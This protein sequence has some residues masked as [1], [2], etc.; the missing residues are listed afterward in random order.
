[1]PKYISGRVKTTPVTGL[2]SDR[3][4][5]LSLAD[6]EPSLGDPTV[7]PSSIGAKPVESG[8]QYIIVAVEGRPGE[9]YWIQNQA[10]VT[11]GSISVFEEGVLVGG[12][13]STTQL[14]FRGTAITAEG[15]GGA[16][17]GYA[18][19]ITLVPP[20]NEKE[21][22]FKESNDFATDTTFTFDSTQNLLAAGDR[23]T[24][25]TGGTVITTTASGFVGIGTT[26]PISNLIA[27]P[28]IGIETL[29]PTLHVEGNIRLT[30]TFIDRLG[31]PGQSG[32]LLIKEDDAF[33]GLRW[34]DPK[35]VTFG[36][37]GL[38]GQIQYRGSTSILEGADLFYYDE[39]NNFVG[40]GSTQPTV[41]LDVIGT[42]NFD[43]DVTVERNFYV[44]GIST[45]FGNSVFTG[46]IDAN[47]NLDV[48][49]QTDLDVL[50]VSQLATFSGNIDANGNLDV[51]GQT[52]LDI[53]NV[54]ELATFS[55]NLDI[56]ASVDIQN[57]LDV[58]GTLDVTGAT[59]LASA[60]GITTTGGD[61][62][63]G[64]DL[65]VAGTFNITDL[66]AETGN[67]TVSLDT[68]NFRATGISTLGN[69]KVS[70]NTVDTTGGN[71]ILQANAQNNAQSID[72]RNR[73]VLNNSTES[74]AVDNGSFETIGGVGIA[75]NLNV[76]G[77]VSFAGDGSGVD[78][79]LAS[80]GGITTTGG[81]LYVGGDF[82]VNRDVNFKDLTVETLTVSVAATIANLTL[83]NPGISVTAIL[84][85]DTMISNRDDALATQ[86]SIKAYVDTQVGNQDLD[87]V[88][89]F[90]A[91][92]AVDLDTQVFDIG[93]VTGDIKTTSSGQ[94]LTIESDITGVI[95]GTY[96]SA[97]R[98]GI[99]TVNDKGKITAASDVDIDLS[100]VTVAAADKLTTP[101][102]I[103]FSEDVVAIGKTFDGTQDVGFALTLTSVFD[104]GT[105]GGENDKVLSLTVDDKGRITG[106]T[107]VAIDF[108]SVGSAEKV[109]I[110]TTDGSEEPYFLTFVADTS[111]A[112]SVYV[113]AGLSYYPTT[114]LVDFD[115]NVRVN[116]NKS[117]C[118]GDDTDYATWSYRSG[119]FAC[120]TPGSLNR[121]TDDGLLITN[122]GKASIFE[123]Q[124]AG[125]T[126]FKGLG[127]GDGAFWFVD[128]NWST[129]L[130]MQATGAGGAN[131]SF[132][133][134][135]GSEILQIVGAGLTVGGSVV[136]TAC[137]T[138]DLGTSTKR[139]N[140]VYAQTICADNVINSG[141]GGGG[142]DADR[143]S[144]GTTTPPSPSQPYYLT[145]VDSNN[146][147][148]SA[149]YLYTSGQIIY[150]A[151][152][153]TL[154]PLNL[155]VTL[156]TDLNRNVTIG[157]SPTDILT[158]NASVGST[159]APDTTDY[160]DLGS[161]ASTRWKT[162]Y[163][164]T[165]C[166]DNYCG[167]SGGGGAADQISVGS[168]DGNQEPYYMTFV[169][170]TS[171]TQNLYT[172]AGL[173]YY[174]TTDEL[175]LDNN[176]LLCDNA[177]LCIGNSKEFNLTYRLIDV[178][179]SYTQ[180][181]PELFGYDSSGILGGTGGGGS[182]ILNRYDVSGNKFT[183]QGKGEFLKKLDVDLFCLEHLEVVKVHSN[184]SVPILIIQV[185]LHQ[186]KKKNGY[187]YSKCMEDIED[188][189]FS[190]AMQIL[191]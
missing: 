12:L 182:N 90:G 7:G 129:M 72:V 81:D 148:R 97:T 142:G 43:G 46:N 174:P 113:G 186:K 165:I 74:T 147:P 171:G 9:R 49:G 160:Y 66:E 53:L 32:Y 111:G 140:T 92:G 116:I 121:C 183:S 102:T 8:N 23:I 5:Y 135:G 60:G 146:N 79:T 36:A 82:Y 126:V 15:L 1:M 115:S 133:N 45:F 87:F 122:T 101:R 109:S 14:D 100:N 33:G 27:T 37:A 117:F 99:I 76:G 136:P 168:T 191:K 28:G 98:V 185:V 57:N 11:P 108:S 137:D 163:A 106:I 31:D 138:Y 152:T 83:D 21:V 124:G 154:N 61:L 173:R 189:D 62:Y 170:N 172:D 94:S 141:G 176:L 4:R 86:Q 178:N 84:D 75:K 95:A 85:E 130:R 110:A 162:V 30:G 80:A 169:P 24:V 38:Y 125:P 123:E 107:S 25:G 10:D 118:L 127:S 48:D 190:N 128:N 35:N 22:I 153:C 161:S 112:Q 69:V 52:D 13:S 3:Y 175:A 114:E 73:I 88:G 63:V 145:F 20:G 44:G 158:V 59:D 56:N 29:D 96:G 131:F 34:Q 156:D 151:S 149:E 134:S 65:Y 143:V 50:N 6:A 41:R 64:N 16:N 42:S 19:T 159:I 104:G 166:A 18:V 167:I 58:G 180:G 120:G 51:D 132:Y 164:Q 47:G 177:S 144:T 179:C 184:S 91:Q 187:H 155:T 77:E 157:D 40:I 2:T 68:V 139:W 26:N 78:V 119:D 103:S 55:A 67:F 54:S 105:Y 70:G 93:G 150:Q 188:L 39:V 89:D 181:D 71:L 17:P